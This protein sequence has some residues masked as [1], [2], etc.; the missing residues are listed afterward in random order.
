[1][2]GACADEGKA[3][4]NGRAPHEKDPG[5]KIR[6]R[7]GGTMGERA[8]ILAGL[9]RPQVPV[10]TIRDRA[11]YDFLMARETGPRI[12][13]EALLSEGQ[14]MTA[15][16]RLRRWLPRRLPGYCLICETAVHFTLPSAKRG[17]AANF[18]EAL[19]CA[20][21]GLNNRQ[22]FMASHA[23]ELL[24]PRAKD[25]KLYAYEQASAFF[26]RMR[27]RLGDRAVGSEYLGPDKSP[28]QVKDGVRH[29]DATALSFPDASFDVIVSN[30][31]FEH[32]PDIRATLSEARRI[33]R[34][35]GTLLFT[36]PFYGTDATEQRAALVAGT[37][38]HLSNPE[39]HGD[40]VCPEEGSLV[41]YHFGWDLLEYCRN[42]GFTTAAMIAYY[43]MLYGHMG[44]GLQYAF[45]ADVAGDK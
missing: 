21:C 5:P 42:A 23:L 30:D 15:P 41:F 44:S 27:E 24:Q 33:L 2:A 35:G 14:G 8:P 7:C 26:D 18:R 4:M 3:W 22:R 45:R 25:S 11:S 29:E 19:L 17:A 12:A 40:P 34:P 6:A 31:V 32:V 16:R 38:Q 43:S 37:V 36:V 1:M 20:G 28:G 13:V 10:R 9:L 39:Y